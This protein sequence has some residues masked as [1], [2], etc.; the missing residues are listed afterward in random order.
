MLGVDVSNNRVTKNVKQK[1]IELKGEIGKI[2]IIV[3]DFYTLPSANNRSIRQKISKDI[4][5]NNTIT[6]RILLTYTEYSS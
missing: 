1:L 6:K 4:K 2:L 3:G 5:F